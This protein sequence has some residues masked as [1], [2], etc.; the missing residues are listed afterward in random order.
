MR[1]VTVC[2]L[3]LVTLSAC[4]HRRAYNGLCAV[5]EF[6][7]H[8]Y[9]DSSNYSRVTCTKYC[10]ASNA[11]FCR[12]TPQAL[13]EAINIGNMKADKQRCLDAGYKQDTEALADCIMVKDNNRRRARQQAQQFEQQ[14]Q[15][16]QGQQELLQQQQAQQMFMQNQQR[17]QYQQQLDQQRIL[18]TMQPQP[19]VRTN[20]TGRDYFGNFSCVSQ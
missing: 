20:C 6:G 1:L 14:Q 8:P 4:H 7:A 18:Q 19:Q 5:N 12:D 9:N 11:E 13:I 17:I 2:I 15:Y 3:L 10:S 16:Q